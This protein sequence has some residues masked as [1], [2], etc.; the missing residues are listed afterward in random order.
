VTAPTLTISASERDTLHGLMRRRLLILGENPSGLAKAEGITGEALCE[1]FGDDLRLMEGIGWV[2]EADRESV[3][4]TM[5]PERLTEALKRLRRD[6]RRAPYSLQ[7]EREPKESVEERWRRFR[8]AVEVCDELLDR[9]E[10]SSREERAAAAVPISTVSPEQVKAH[11]PTPYTPVTDGFILAA[12]ERTE[13]HEREGEVLTSELTA[14]LGFEG[15]PATNRLLF[16]R[17]EEL[18]HAGLLTSTERRGEPFWS[19]TSVGRE[20]LAK[21]REASEV[22]ELPES[23]Q[24]RAWRHARVQ[25]AVQIDQFRGEQTQAIGAAYELTYRYEPSASAEWFLMAE[26]LRW[27][28]WRMA[29]AIHCLYEWPE[30]DDEFPDVDENPGPSPGRRAI[31]AWDKAPPES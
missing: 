27:T 6:A 31:S 7:H 13:L 23:P 2:F 22:G 14:H 20:R 29:S 26:R 11:E 15:K 8:Q 5:P 9:L 3:E 21:E 18:R 19:L 12:L 1:Q 24:H 30:P 17:L 25:A 28:T 4:L 16:P 10:S